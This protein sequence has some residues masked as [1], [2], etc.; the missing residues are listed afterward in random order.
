[1]AAFSRNASDKLQAFVRKG[2]V[3]I[4]FESAVQQLAVNTDWG[5]KIKELP[6]A[7][8]VDVNNVPKYGESVTDYLRSS[9][10]GVQSTYTFTPLS[11][12]TTNLYLLSPGF[13][14]QSTLTY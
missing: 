11:G 4:A 8:K 3:L 13:T 10:P 12:G 6:K 7:E 1:M 2:G 9:I 5:I 14:N